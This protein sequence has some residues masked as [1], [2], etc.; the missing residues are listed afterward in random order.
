[1]KLNVDLI[2]ELIAQVITIN[3]PFLKYVEQLKKAG[4]LSYEVNCC[5]HQIYFR[6]DE[7]EYFPNTSGMVDK[8]DL[9]NSFS[10]IKIKNS[11]NLIRNQKIDYLDFLSELSKSGVETYLVLIDK[12]ITIYRG[13]SKHYIEYF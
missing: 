3:L 4:V 12:K 10:E 13:N 5:T 1:M 2:N 11:L 9:K 8:N 6:S 7:D